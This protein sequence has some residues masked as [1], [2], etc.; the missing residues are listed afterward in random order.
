MTYA[1]KSYEHLKG[2][3]LKGFSDNQLDLPFT[4]YQGYLAKP[5]DAINEYTEPKRLEYLDPFLDNLK[6]SEVSRRITFAG[7]HGHG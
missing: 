7:C 3:A 4:L 6:W 2:G 5:S 1:P